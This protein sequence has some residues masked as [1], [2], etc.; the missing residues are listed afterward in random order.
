MIWDNE[1]MTLR[2][3]CYEGGITILG[4]LIWRKYILN[5]VEFLR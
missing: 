3:I 2:V 4:S 1:D 5:N